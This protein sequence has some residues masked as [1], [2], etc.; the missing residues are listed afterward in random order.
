M[1]RQLFGIGLAACLMATS[2]CATLFAGGQ[3][4]LTVTV[5]QPASATVIVRATNTDD[6]ETTTGPVVHH[7]MD[8]G[9]P[10]AIAVSADHYYSTMEV[11][12]VSVNPWYWAD[13]VPLLVGTVGAIAA[14]GDPNTSGAIAIGGDSAFVVAILIDIFTKNAY[15]H[16]KTNFTVNL[17]PAPR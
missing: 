8:R 6:Q 15:Q 13:L 4:D 16:D 2:G 12:K 9:S 3:E 11:T 1:R 7:V 17:R 10:Y 14:G 5:Q